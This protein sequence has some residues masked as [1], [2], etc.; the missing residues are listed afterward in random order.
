[1]CTRKLMV[2]I[3]IVLVS[4]IHAN[5]DHMDDRFRINGYSS[6]EFEKL[7]G[8]TG[9]GDPNASFDADLFDLVLNIQA[10]D[11]LRIA[12]DITWEHGAA[13]EDDRGNVAIEYAFPEYLV[14]NALRIRAGK[15]FVPFG[16]YNEIHTA[17]P[18]FLSVKEPLSTNKNHKFGSS[19]R[20]YPRWAIGISF[21][22]NA[23]AGNVD[24]DYVIQISNGD[25]EN[26]NPYEVDDNTA[27][28]IAM[29]VQ[30]QPSTAIELGISY[31]RDRLTE[32][33]MLGA[34]T[35]E[36][37][38][39]ESVGAHLQWEFGSVGLEAEFVTG[40]VD[41][42]GPTGIRRKALTTMIYVTAHS[43]I[44]PYVRFEWLD[45]DV[46]T[47]ADEAL[48]YIYGIN[49]RVDEGL[50]LKAELNTIRSKVANA[51]FSDQGY[52]EFKAA[53]AVG[54]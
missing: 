19:I 44:T 43:Y 8:S 27:K 51:R 36:R 33:D 10:T 52:T 7:L 12:A 21:L 37:T 53:I 26:T 38:L 41:P 17:K 50:F 4:C 42:S 16:I 30:A 34:D 23:T 29:R 3:A 25:Q 2:T 5:A 32:Y 18:V 46:D 28:A 54:F 47:G 24:L 20:F 6:F 39:V 49:A 9:K 45:P 14:T 31:Y 40:R 48:M 13:S 1:M 22:G 15:M 35:G 11:R